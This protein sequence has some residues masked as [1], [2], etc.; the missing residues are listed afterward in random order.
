MATITSVDIEDKEEVVIIDITIQHSDVLTD[1]QVENLANILSQ[2]MNKSVVP[3][4]T[5]VPIVKL[6]ENNNN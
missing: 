3:R 6:W 1:S 4:I 5:I 2:K